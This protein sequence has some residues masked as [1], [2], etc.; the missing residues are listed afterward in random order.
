MARVEKSR[1][2]EPIDVF[3]RTPFEVSIEDI[4]GKWSKKAKS[5]RP[6][7]KIEHFSH[8][9]SNTDFLGSLFI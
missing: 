9:E 4:C 1:M 3:M 8:K 7:K 6:C 5:Y 2:S